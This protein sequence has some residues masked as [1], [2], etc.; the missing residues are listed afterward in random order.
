[1]DSKRS[2]GKLSMKKILIIILLFAS[3]NTFSQNIFVCTNGEVTFFS[4]GPIEDIDATSKSMNS[5]L[6]ISTGEIV[7][8]VPMTSFN[9]RKALMQEHFNEK[10]VESDKYPK[11]TYKGKINEKID[12]SKDGEYD[13]TSLGILNIHN[14]DKEHAEKGKLIIKD[15]AISIKSEFNVAVADHKIEIPKL[16][17]DNIADT[18]KVTFS[19]SYIPFKKEK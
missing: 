6:N 14:V 8:V 5:I 15:G 7:F 9:F 2:T 17:V 4:K 10:Y 12:Y 16:L 13:I 19:A 3:Y 11:G 18:V 1:M